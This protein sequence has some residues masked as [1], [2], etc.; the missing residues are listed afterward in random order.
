MN[1]LL[2]DIRYGIRGLIKNPG[3]TVVSVLALALAIGTVTP[4]FSFINTYLLRPLPFGDPERLVHVWGTDERQGWDTLRVSFP[5]YFDWK[6]QNT[7]FEDLAAFNYTVE[8]L[9][10]GDR[11]QQL[12]GGRISANCFDVLGVRPQMGR[13]FQ[14][15]E[16]L[17]GASQVVI[18]SHR[19]WT[20]R[21]GADPQVLGK[22]I[23]IN[24][25]THT[26]IGVMPE[27]FLFPLPNTQLWLPRIYDSQTDIRENRYLQILGRLKP[28]VG[29]SQAQ[30][31]M[32]LI[33]RRLAAQFP[34]ENANRGVN[35]ADLRSALNFADEIFR[36]MAVIM[37]GA[38]LFVLLIACANVS[39]L[40]LS[41]GLSR[42]REMA[43][44]TA[45]GASR[46]QL[47]RLL[48]VESSVLSLTAAFLGL[49]LAYG[50][51]Q[52]ASASIPDELYR[53]GR[54]ELDGPAILFTL[55]V[56]LI[57]AM[58]FGLVPALRVSRTGLVTPLK[59]G[60]G[61]V[62]AG[63]SNLRLQNAMVAVELGLAMVLLVGA[64]LML[65]TLWQLG[66]VHPGFESEG[67]LS[68]RIVLPDEEYN[69]P[70]QRLSFQDQLL[71]RVRALPA[72]TAAATVNHLPLNHEMSAAEYRVPGESAAPDGQAPTAV[73]LRVSPDYFR[74]MGI[75]LLGGRGF[76]DRDNQT[77]PPVMV[78]NQ[79]LAERLVGGDQDVVG[80]RLDVEGYE[81]SFTVVG[82]VG[83]TKHW[84]LA[85][86]PRAQI[87][88][89]QR[90]RPGGYF[91]LVTRTP[92]NPLDLVSPLRDSIRDLDPYLP[93][94]EVRSMDQVVSEFLLPQRVIA[95][96][97]GALSTGALLLALIG[98]YGLMA[99]FVSLRR[100]EVGIR[101]ALGARRLD[102]VRLIMGR[103]LALTVA[104]LAGGVVISFLMARLMSGLLFG[105]GALNP[106]SF[107][108]VP[109]LLAGAALLFCYIPARRAAQVDPLSTLRYE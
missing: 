10:G 94:S 46:K 45:L 58:I 31:E 59:E 48:L 107:L 53:V 17:P 85:E 74:V 44:R 102:V 71:T 52:L 80:M 20:T 35:V 76:E 84:D 55:A 38:N 103:G 57:T 25:R 70:A 47:V 56:S 37:S 7:V 6:E 11:P 24:R 29:R 21:L 86:G 54:M 4:T 100:R 79:L 96:F 93:L 60:A 13:S 65:Q 16:D 106:V 3:F 26:V 14:R 73:L 28:D 15:G 77:S 34:D 43:V 36:V 64:S 42:A 69:A 50:L 22:E 81:Q 68:L 104:G 67:V 18:L 9:T 39:S 19:F 108:L 97:L 87:Y 51:V 41:R 66:E 82:V 101:M 5:D 33:A 92:G 99:F 105:V 23:E 49:L 75:P 1:T 90:Q 63:R 61:A 91:R 78:I 62:S 98:I 83:N 8:D 32:D 72:V 89:A 88:F 109:L 40:L 27:E 2:R 95:G 12:P 30:Q